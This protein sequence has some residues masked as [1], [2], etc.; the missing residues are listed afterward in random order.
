MA[1]DDVT[2]QIAAALAEVDG[3][4]LPDETWWEAEAGT[5]VANPPAATGSY[6]VD[7]IGWGPYDRVDGA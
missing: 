2:A 6:P 3:A 5:W 7:I 4:P 1:E